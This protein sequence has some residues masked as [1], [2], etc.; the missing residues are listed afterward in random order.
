MN[1][2]N[3]ALTGRGVPVLSNKP[4]TPHPRPWSRRKKQPRESRPERQARMARLEHEPIPQL[5]QRNP[6]FEAVGFKPS[7]YTRCVEGFLV[8]A[9]RRLKTIVKNNRMLGRRFTHLVNINL[10]APRHA[11]LIN[12]DFR[13]FIKKLEKT[14][15]VGHWTIEID[16]RNVVHWHLLFANFSG[17]TRT[18]KALVQACLNSVPTFPGRR[19]HAERIKSQRCKLE[20]V[21]KIKKAGYGD[22]VNPLEE[23][24]GGR[25][26]AS[27]DI[28]ARDRVLFK[29]NTGL[30]KHGT[31]GRF[32]AEGFNEK[33]MWALIR[34]ET[35]TVARNYEIPRL[36]AFVHMLSEKLAIPLARVKW[37]YC[38]NPS[39][40]LLGPSLETRRRK[41][42]LVHLSRRRS[43]GLV[44]LVFARR[45]NRPHSAPLI[46]R[47][48]PVKGSADSLCSPQPPRA[49]LNEKDVFRRSVEVSR[50]TGDGLAQT[51]LLLALTHVTAWLGWIWHL[52]PKV[53]RG[54]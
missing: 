49:A 45:S 35:A 14:G 22:V 41:A 27:R 51:R 30:D 32:W 10:E 52:V 47:D 50:D 9:R 31:F 39:G 54:P 33:K 13:V 15:V 17:S 34:E 8:S 38:L 2:T 19:V 48:P 43:A 1:G 16:R 29:P 25:R 44:A 18:L 36:R 24:A 42:R 4:H 21:L 40:D 3:Q 5:F 53:G 26:P 46:S 7:G 11:A 23:K 20:Y 12:R 28:Y 6:F 37:A